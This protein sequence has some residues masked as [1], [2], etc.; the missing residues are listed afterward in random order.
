MAKKQMEKKN[1]NENEETLDKVQVKEEESVLQETLVIDMDKLSQDL[2]EM[3]KEIFEEPI[4]EKV[5]EKK[6]QP[7]FVSS[8]NEE[9]KKETI[10]EVKNK[11]PISNNFFGYVWN[12]QEYDY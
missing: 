6:S 9:P 7:Q 4:V 8:K 3:K 10:K 5:A 11:K 1:I 12:G 2:E